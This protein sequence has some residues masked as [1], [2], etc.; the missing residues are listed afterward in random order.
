MPV[1]RRARAT[2]SLRRPVVWVSGFVAMVCVCSDAAAQRALAA[3]SSRTVGDW[4]ACGCSGP[5]YT[6]SFLICWRPSGPFGQ[7][8]VDAAADG[9]GGLA[10]EQ[11]VVPLRL[12]AAGVAAVAVDLLVVGLALGEHDLVGVDDDHVVAGV[13]VRGERRLVLAA[14][15]AGGLGAQATEH[16]PVGVDDVPGTR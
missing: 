4:A 15:H 2:A 7:H 16:E 13:D 11:V 3:G 8:P 5:E 1:R 14:Q 12:Q 10:A 9:V 6:L